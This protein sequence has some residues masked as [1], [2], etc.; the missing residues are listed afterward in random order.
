VILGWEVWFGVI[1]LA[2]GLGATMAY[3]V[4]RLRRGY[5]RKWTGIYFCLISVLL[6]SALSVFSFWQ[7][8]ETKDFVRSLKNPA[9]PAHLA[10]DWGAK[11][12]AEERVKHSQ[13]LA[14]TTFVDWGIHVNHFDLSGNS[15]QYEPTDED[16]TNRAL[17]LRYIEL[18]A[19]SGTLLF[20]TGLGWILVPWIGLA[21]A[22]IPGAT[23]IA[24]TLTSRSRAD[25]P[26]VGGA[27][28]S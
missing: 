11:L 21:F 8:H 28:L 23:R 19:V 15:R 24:G 10:A 4:L 22:F 25:A 20:W 9:P 7:S 12:T 2:V 3:G 27:P 18:T 13:M 26:P 6:S 14:R 16:R 17:R 5:G 1:A